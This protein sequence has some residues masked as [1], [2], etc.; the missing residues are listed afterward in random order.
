MVDSRAKTLRSFIV[1]S[2]TVLKLSGS[3]ATK[4]AFSNK[5]AKPSPA[6]CRRA[7]LRAPLRIFGGG[8]CANGLSIS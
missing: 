7:N 8:K 1:N 3:R 2:G 4:A 6:K 5:P